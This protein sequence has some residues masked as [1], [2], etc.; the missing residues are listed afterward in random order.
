M[1]SISNLA[2]LSALVLGASLL[3]GCGSDSSEPG[4]VLLTCDVP[5]V[6]DASG[7]QCV[8]PPPKVCQ[9]P[10]FPD[11]KNENCIVGYNP[12]LP[13][14]VVFAGKNQ[15]VLYYNRIKDKD[16][17]SANPNYPGYKLHTW[18]NDT[19]DAYA[20]P[21]DT[22]S[23]ANGHPFDGID[24]N[25]GA[26]WILTLKEGHSDCANFIVHTGTEGSGKALGDGDLKMNLKPFEDPS[27][28]EARFDRVNFTIHGESSVYD[29][30]ILD[31]GFSIS[32]ASAHWLDKD[33]LV[34][35]ESPEGIS[36]FVLLHSPN[37]DIGVD[38][39][40]NLSG[41]R[42]LLTQTELNEVQKAQVPQL[43][44]WPAYRLSHSDTEA[45]ALVKEQLVLAGLDA[46]GKPLAATYVQNARALDDLYT[47][48]DADANEASLGISY[49]GDAVTARLWAPTAQAVTL[50]VYDEAKNL[51]RSE[52]M[53]EDP[54]TGIWSFTGTGLD[55]RYYRYELTLYHPVSKKLETVEST[56][57]Y[58]VNVSANGRFSQ[59]VNLSDADTKPDGWDGHMVPEGA[60]PEDI[61]VYEGHVRDFSIRDDSTSAANRGKY[62]AFTE[63]G[64]APVEHLRSL[65]QKG[66]THFHVLPVTDMATV[67]ELEDERV[68]LTDTLG[69]LCGK[70]NDSAD[71]CKTKDKGA[72]IQ[73]LLEDSLPGSADAQ[74]LV[75]AMRGLDGFNWGYDPQHFLAP[76]GSYASS[77][78]GVARVKELRAMN[79]ALHGIGLRTVLDVVYNHTSS[80]GLYDNSV[81][82]KVVPGYYHRYDPVTGAMQRSTCCE[83]TATEHAMMAKLMNDTL[84]SLAQDFGFDGFRFDIM[85]HIPKSAMLAAR[86]AVRAVDPDTYFYGEGWNFGEVA[87]NRLF[88]QATQANLAGT[89]VGSFNDRIREAIRGGSLFQSELKDEVLRDQDTLRLSMAG[90]L[91]DYVLK[92]FN[93]NSAKGSSFSWN[94]QPTAYATDPA[95]I[96]NYV[97]KHDNETLWDKL[98]Y[99]LPVGMSL[100]DR[101]RAQN[102]AATVPLLSQGIPFLQLGGDMLRSKSMDR[103]S[104]DSGDWFNYVDFTQSGNNWN[105]GL[106]L[107]QDNQG[108]WNTISGISANPNTAASASEIGFAAEVFGEF[109]QIRHQSKLFRL[110]T[111][112]DIIARVGFHNVGKRQTQGVIVMSLDD[113]AG[114]TDLDPAVDAIVVMVNGT[115]SSQS[116][117]VPTASGFSLHPLLASSIDARVR[118][119]SFSAG[120]NEGTFTVPAYT[121]AVFVKAQG[122]A[123]G[124]GLS[125]NA[126]VG[127]PD[128]VPYGS[129]TVY[130]RGS[131]NGWGTGNP[132]QYVGNGEYRVAITLAPGDYEFKLASED[133]STV[134]FGGVSADVADVEE[135]VVEQLAAKGANLKF[136]ATLAATYVFSLDASDKDNPQLTV[137]NEEPFP[138]TQVYLRGDMNGWG[139]DNA[140]TYLGGGVYRA[141]VALTAGSKGFKLASSDWSTVDF[142][143]GEADGSVT[144]GVEKLLAVK[145]GNLSMNF[146][147]DTSYS[148]IFDLSNRS[149][150]LLTVFKTDIFAGT[151]VFL[152]GGM[153]GW[154]TDN[155]L[156]YQGAGVYSTD[157]SL[158]AGAVEFK[159]AS[160]DWSTVDFGALSGDVADVALDEAEPL[161][162]KGTNLKLNVAEAGTYRFTVAGPDPS[163]PSLT[164]TRVN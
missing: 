13:D 157:V 46:D 158:G 104:Y 80:S 76:E 5:M 95:D 113:G 78:D 156:S 154:G 116:H 132:L 151:Q 79:M 164:V 84:V 134:D 34:W 143:S 110:T 103:N 28:A 100:E 61:V 19:C 63:E 36:Q 82:D 59:F 117:T 77:P 12:E 96:I 17:S 62:L 159:V 53:T 139:S 160:S 54:A 161:A 129:T 35:N 130:V 69:K 140:M 90:N 155:P 74:A 20:P 88:E 81:L 4:Q 145:G 125:A 146:D 106:P 3:W 153:N 27:A 48:G 150:P 105:V 70:I 141:D 133:W 9:A 38:E 112:E 92:D 37:A 111:A 55:R 148:F 87:D 57:P 107:A 29:F 86:D 24:P 47:S 42:L 68:E 23:W 14:P 89:E 97:S 121:T 127:A 144:L 33:T 98:Q 18:N 58:S 126:T 138:G 102:I 119:A 65:A 1:L 115:A 136:S 118:G 16:N 137:Y 52:T 7:T 66:L 122:A 114:L 50:K 131:L 142:G 31:V 163:A 8:A 128:V 72:T 25:Y 11:A 15:A 2:R 91:K 93:G 40:G 39:R 73:S 108:N 147:E 45:R 149:E 85:G 99:S 64:S 67:N 6:P 109:L 49:E 83:N 43:A 51:T 75:N 162:A 44:N 10:T 123:Q 30:P 32:G 56:D 152:R 60:D 41:A 71:A 21:F 120:D 101:V 124:E 26:Y 22:S 94:S 135:G